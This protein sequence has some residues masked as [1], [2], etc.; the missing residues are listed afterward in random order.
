M[1]YSTTLSNKFLPNQRAG[2]PFI[3]RSCAPSAA[4]KK[5]F[6]S[7]A[8][9]MLGAEFSLAMTTSICARTR[10]HLKCKIISLKENHVISFP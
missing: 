9:Y 5:T 3:I 1:K 2:T 10:G 7:R 8:S 6:K 4:V